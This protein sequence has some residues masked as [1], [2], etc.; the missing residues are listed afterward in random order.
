MFTRIVEITAKQGK[1]NEVAETIQE[2]AL[3]TLK[4]QP[5]CEVEELLR[6]R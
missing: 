5:G 2:K 4:K 3:P 6:P 1:T